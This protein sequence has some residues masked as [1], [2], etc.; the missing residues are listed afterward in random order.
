M[1]FFVDYSQEK[2]IRNYLDA[3]WKFTYRKH[4]RENIQERLLQNYPPDFRTKLLGTKTKLGAKKVVKNFLDSRPQNFN[5]ITALVIKVCQLVL[6]E[7]KQNIVD[8]LQTIYQRPVP[9]NKITVYITTLPICPYDYE[10]RWFMVNRNN[11]VGGFINTA[12]HELN[13]FMFYYYYLGSLI[14]KGVSQE[15]REKLKEALAIFSNPEGNDK[16]DVKELEAYLKVLNGKSMD[17]VI[18][19]VLNSK[20]LE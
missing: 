8:L 3:C 1:Q 18:D 5:R 20:Y 4:G 11:S 13:H 14:Q 7:E 19:L 10:N 12:K 16:P 9:F 6:D 2:D 17:E 15:K